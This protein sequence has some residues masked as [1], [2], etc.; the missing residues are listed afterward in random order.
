MRKDK[1]KNAPAEQKRTSRITYKKYK[2]ILNEIQEDSQKHMIL[3]HILEHGSITKKEAEKKPIYSRRLEARIY[4][5]RHD[6]NVPIRT[7]MIFKKRG[8]KTIPHASYYIGD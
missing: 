6:Y 4:E 3:K 5:L 7:E 8:K 1:K 2:P